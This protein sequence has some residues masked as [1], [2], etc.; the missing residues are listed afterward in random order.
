MTDTPAAII[1]DLAALHGMPCFEGG[2]ARLM[3]FARR[4]RAR[5]DRWNAVVPGSAP[6]HDLGCPVCGA[7]ASGDCRAYKAESDA[8]Y[9]H[10]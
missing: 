4:A 1:G 5:V 6:H 7:P 10:A 2:Y 3:E 8:C 9:R